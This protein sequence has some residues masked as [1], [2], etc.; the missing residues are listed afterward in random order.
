MEFAAAKIAFQAEFSSPSGLRPVPTLQQRARENSQF[1]GQHDV[2][3]SHSK[4]QFLT[5]A[6]TGTV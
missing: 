6:A 2:G 3:F 5:L 4:R 1:N